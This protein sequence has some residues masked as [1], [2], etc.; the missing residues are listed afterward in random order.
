MP[1]S[2]YTQSISNI[3][4]KLNAEGNSE[5][6]H[7]QKTVNNL[8]QKENKLVESEK[9]LVKGEQNYITYEVRDVVGYDIY[10]RRLLNDYVKNHAEEK[11]DTLSAV[12]QAFDEV[13]KKCQ[14]DEKVYSKE[15]N[16][17]AYCF[18]IRALQVVEAENMADRLANDNSIEDP[19]Q[20]NSVVEQNME[21]YAFGAAK[22]AYLIK[23]NNEFQNADSPEW[24][25]EI[26]DEINSDSLDDN[27]KEYIKNDP[28][29]K[30]IHEYA[31]RKFGEKIKK[32]DDVGVKYFSYLIPSIIADATHDFVQKRYNEAFYDYDKPNLSQE[33]KDRIEKI[34]DDLDECY[35]IQKYINTDYS[36]HL[37]EHIYY[38]TEDIRIRSKIYGDIKQMDFLEDAKA[39]GEKVEDKKVEDKKEDRK[40]DK[41][42]EDE[43]RIKDYESAKEELER[44]KLRKK[45]VDDKLKANEY[46]HKLSGVE[47]SGYLRDTTNLGQEIAQLDKHINEKY[48][49]IIKKESEKIKEAENVKESE[50]AKNQQD[51]L[52][53]SE[54]VKKA[55]EEEKQK[56]IQKDIENYNNIMNLDN[57]PENIKKKEFELSNRYLKEMRRRNGSK[58][59][60]YSLN[61]KKQEIVK[62]KPIVDFNY[63]NAILALGEKLSQNKVSTQ[64]YMEGLTTLTYNNILK[65]KYS[66]RK[67]P[68]RKNRDYLY[69]KDQPKV[70]ENINNIN[71]EKISIINEEKISIGNEEK[72]NASVVVKKTKKK[73]SKP[74]FEEEPE[75]EEIKEVEEV[76]EIKQNNIKPEDKKED[77]KEEKNKEKNEE[78]NEDKIQEN[79][80]ENIINLGR[81]SKISEKS[82]ISNNRM[83][84]IIDIDESSDNSSDLGDNFSAVL[85]KGQMIKILENGNKGVWGGTEQYD[86]ILKEL[87]AI[88]EVIDNDQE[89]INR[90]RDLILDMNHYIS[91]KHD[92]KYESERKGGKE[93]ANSKKRRL[94]LEK[95]RENLIQEIRRNEAN[96]GAPDRSV[97]DIIHEMQYATWD[98]KAV[99][100]SKF[101]EKVTRKL[102]EMDKKRNDPDVDRKTVLQEEMKVLNDMNQYIGTRRSKYVDKKGDYKF[103]FPNNKNNNKKRVEPIS[104]S[105]RRFKIMLQSYE[106]LADVFAKDFEKERSPQEV[107]KI[108]ET[109]GKANRAYKLNIQAS[110]EPSPNSQLNQN[111]QTQK[112]KKKTTETVNEG[113]KTTIGKK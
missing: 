19:A 1:K 97:R 17:S 23:L 87:K 62:R 30:S 111:R 16:S 69:K 100:T 34:A 5:L 67:A 113:K 102:V 15:I 7:I 79:I 95:V 53:I 44:L 92:E 101:F 32:G 63:S 85:T 98:K 56:E 47:L 66:A 65:S 42:I 4:L 77:K 83:S 76:E 24:K 109:F 58:D 33:E 75:I 94:A 91:R 61:S 86:N 48:P 80:N 9:K 2:N 28:I 103:N 8:N 46:S 18:Q 93:N 36:N 112:G 64:E 35:G 43:N 90:K 38:D 60:D 25:K 20:R 51:R 50:K 37:A 72:N 49:D 22:I 52:V 88:D 13:D 10:L 57:S 71:E 39:T 3:L 26:L 74:K 110:K 78:K 73:P 104:A 89:L 27:V 84:G 107:E 45:E 82:K 59:Y 31:G 14:E 29:G 105:E 106:K 6:Q 68:K 108:K 21:S 11:N 70:E 96:Y 99:G 40:E 54:E 81:S 12:S 55:F 41:I